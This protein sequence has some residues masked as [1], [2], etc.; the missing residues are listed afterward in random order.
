MEP[1]WKD[2]KRSSIQKRK[3][4]NKNNKNKSKFNIF[5]DNYVKDF[6][7]YI[8]KKLDSITKYERKPTAK[9]IYFLFERGYICYIGMSSNLYSRIHD[10]MCGAGTTIMKKNEKTSNSLNFKPWDHF[11]IIE[12]DIPMPILQNIEKELILKYKPKYNKRH[13]L[14]LNKIKKEKNHYLRRTSMRRCHHCKSI[15]SFDDKI[16]PECGENKS[17]D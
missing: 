7:K 5:Y 2:L 8:E 9:G 3:F 14:E 13:L 12:M 17:I 11:A 16:C 6:S 10:H 15:F 1:S 4:Y